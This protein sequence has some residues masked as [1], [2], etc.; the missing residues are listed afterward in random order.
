MKNGVLRVTN[1]NLNQLL[2][3]NDQHI[4]VRDVDTAQKL[5]SQ[6]LDKITLWAHQWKMQ[7]NADI[8]KQAIEVIFSSKYKKVPH[9]P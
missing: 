2:A 3:K 6:D 1:G 9:P 5:L 7:Y 4:K 8:T